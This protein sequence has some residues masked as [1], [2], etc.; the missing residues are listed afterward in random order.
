[1]T[2]NAKGALLAL[3]AFGIF[4][5]H[6]IVIKVLGGTYSPIQI[7]F[8]SVVLS[9]PL[10]TLWLLR[11]QTSGTLIPRHPYWMVARTVAAVIT[12]FSAFY[13]FSVLPLAQVYAIIFASP[14]LITVLAIPI[15]GEEVRLR[16][17]L[18]VLVGL[19]GVLVVLRPGQTE[20]G[21]GHLAALACAVGGAFASVIVRKIG[22][23]ERTVVIML[24]PMM[25]NFLVMGALLPTVYVP[26]PIEDLGLIAI[27]AVFAWIAGRFLIGAYN[28]GE[29]V[30]VAPM[31]YSQILWATVY[32][33][34]FFDEWPDFGT[35]VGSAIIIASGMYIV[36]RESRST[37]SG[38]PVLNTR[39]RP[40]TGTSPRIGS[41]MKPFQPKK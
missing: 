7:V 23:E 29:A 41:F 27:V 14:L 24:Y 40:E 9:F 38:T 32:G 8:F 36:L 22:R 5:T 33:A 37:T 11:D 26:M 16:R 25:A 20:L 15:L 3:V 34:L 17:W 4:A 18:A 10:A 39:S 6:D 35:L 12:G 19:C 30:I 31:Q 1:M 21:L 2:P 13:A 28:T